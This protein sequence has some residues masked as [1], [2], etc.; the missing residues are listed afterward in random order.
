ML[1]CADFALPFMCFRAHSNGENANLRVYRSESSYKKT[2]RF[3]NQL[4]LLEK[5][6]LLVRYAIS[7]TG[8]LIGFRVVTAGGG[9][10]QHDAAWLVLRKA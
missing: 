2:V 3:V 9:H 7:E 4:S 8:V 10:A 1:T 5:T 6:I